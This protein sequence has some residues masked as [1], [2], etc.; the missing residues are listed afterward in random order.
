MILVCQ[1]CQAAE[2]GFVTPWGLKHWPVNHS[3]LYYTLAKFKTSNCSGQRNLSAATDRP[4]NQNGATSGFEM[5]FALQHLWCRGPTKIRLE[6]SIKKFKPHLIYDW[7]LRPM[8]HFMRLE[9]S[10]WTG[11]EPKALLYDWGLRPM[12]LEYSGWTGIEPKALLFEW[13][14][15]PMRLEYSGWTG[16]EPKALLFEWCRQN[17]KSKSQPKFSKQGGGRSFK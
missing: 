5:C 1:V 3:I 12:R 10:G 17:T 13:G 9:Y 6:S 4:I 7:G 2:H 15:R 11:I 14:F 8:R 16:I